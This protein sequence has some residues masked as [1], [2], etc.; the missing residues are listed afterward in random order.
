MMKTKFRLANRLT[1]SRTLI[2]EPWADELE[3]A[4]G[5]TY[6]IVAEGAPDSA[7][8][9]EIKSDAIILYAHDNAGALVTVFDEDGKAV[10]NP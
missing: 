9:I 3:M 1:E 4:P 5:A 6:N 10:F 8:E 2:I 7:F